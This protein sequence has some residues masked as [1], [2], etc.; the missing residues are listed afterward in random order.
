MIVNIY[1]IHANSEAVLEDLKTDNKI[2]DV[3]TTVPTYNGGVKCMVIS[4]SEI[5]NLDTDKLA[6]KYSV[7]YHTKY[8]IMDLVKHLSCD[9]SNAFIIISPTEKQDIIVDFTLDSDQYFKLIDKV[10]T[11][12]EI[13][14]NKN[15]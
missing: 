8:S 7:D 9:F 4:K 10:K 2:G 14:E 5:T 3:Y 11:T 12:A 15:K 1:E 6:V 13:E